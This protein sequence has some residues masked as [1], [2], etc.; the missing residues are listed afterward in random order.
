VTRKLDTKS[1]LLTGSIDKSVVGVH[2]I[3]YVVTGI[4]SRDSSVSIVSGY[5]LD[6]RAIGGRSPAEAVDFYS[7][8]YVQTGS[9]ARPAL[10]PMVTGGKVRPERDADHTPASSAEVKN[11]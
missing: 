6:D 7:C 11:E 3:R 1:L 5:V 4:E 8:S 10:Y 2:V 9:G